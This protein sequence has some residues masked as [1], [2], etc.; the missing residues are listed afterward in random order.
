MPGWVVN[1]ASLSLH[2]PRCLPIHSI[3][4]VRVGGGDVAEAADDR[5]V[6]TM[7]SQVS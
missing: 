7:T 5:S 1:W 6:R 3:I 2:R 4:C